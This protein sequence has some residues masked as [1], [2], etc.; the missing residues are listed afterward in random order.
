MS[1]SRSHPARRYSIMSP[2]AKAAPRRW[3]MLTKSGVV[4]GS[5]RRLIAAYASKIADHVCAWAAASPARYRASSSAKAASKSSRSNETSAT[6]RSSALISTM[7]SS[8]GEKCL[9]SLDRD[10]RTG[11]ARGRGA[12]RESP[13]RSVV[14]FVS[15]TSAITRMAC[16]LDVST[17]S[18]ARAHHPTAIVAGKV[19]GQYLQPWRPSRLPRSAPRSARPLGLP[20]FPAAAPGG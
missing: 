9:G 8:L 15:D 2:D 5:S 7:Q 4:A 3:S 18:N 12:R 10:P 16:D 17:M 11:S 6:I 19:V 13:C 20:R 1:W 14:T